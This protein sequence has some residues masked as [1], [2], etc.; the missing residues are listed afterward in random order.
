VQAALEANPYFEDSSQST[1]SFTIYLRAESKTASI[2]IKMD[3]SQ[4]PSGTVIPEEQNFVLGEGSVGEPILQSDIEKA[5]TTLTS[6]GGV[7]D[8]TSST[9][10]NWNVTSLSGPGNTIISTAGEM[11]NQIAAEKLSDLVAS[12]P[13]Y[14]AGNSVY[15]IHMSYNGTLSLRVPSTI[16]FG[17]HEISGKSSTYKGSMEKSV[18]VI[19]SRTTP[20]AWTLKVQQSSP[21]IGYGENTGVIIP[22][23]ELSGSLH[24][25]DTQS[26][27]TLLTDDTS[28]TVYQQTSGSNELVEAMT[29]SNE[30]EKGFYLDTLA[31]KQISKWYGDNVVY[32]GEILWTV[33]NTP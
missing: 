31:N 6:G 33:S 24:F 21:L 18:Y 8:I 23:L 14:L 1:N 30:G 15:E 28:A 2:A 29:N 12:Q 9:Y 10:D 26:N 11:N 5:L 3:N 4:T 13:Y 27:D 22:Q 7:L 32:K 20:T 25:V 17:N 16:D 19:D